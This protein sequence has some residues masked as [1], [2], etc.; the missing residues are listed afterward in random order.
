MTRTFLTG[1][2]AK[3]LVT[4]SVLTALLLSTAATASRAATSQAAAPITVGFSVSLSGD[5]SG[6]GKATLQGYRLWA[7]YTNS[8]GGLL[9]RKVKLIYYDDNSSTTQV[10]TNYTKLMTQDKVDLA[11]GPFSSLLTIPA[12]Q[13]ARRYGYAFLGPA[14]G[15]PSVFQQGFHNYFF[16]QPAP[17]QDNLVSFAHWILNMP[18]SKRP[19]TAAY[20]TLVDPFAQPE[21]E[22]AR[23]VLQRGGVKT[24][25]STVIPAEATDF[26]SE[27]LQAV[28][29]KADIVL[30]G[31]PG[32]NLSVALIHTFIQQHYNPKAYVATS[33]PDQGSQYANA[34]GAKNTEGTMVPE[35]WWSGEKSF[36]NKVFVRAY[37]HTYGG[38]A[39]G[40]SQDTPEAFSVGQVITQ[41]VKRT[42]SLNNARLINYLHNHSFKTVQGPMRWNSK[43]EPLGS[44]FLVQWQHGNTY[45]VY[46]KRFA[47]RSPEYPKAKW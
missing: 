7:N 11:F 25:Y 39:S 23:S 36:Q 46:P 10:T 31:S 26:S 17:V 3:R 24:V 40:I 27:A 5:F 4:A 19:K 33:G 14:G 20:L 38:K 29:S 43:G 15:G 12:A 13:V 22:T 32:M 6:D 44:M 9:G 34:I 35:G 41:A 42:H 18:K 1:A 21:V 2:V 37:L 8:H 45:P 28:H 16:V 30:V 47:V